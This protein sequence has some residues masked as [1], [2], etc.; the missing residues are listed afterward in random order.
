MLACC[1]ELTVEQLGEMARPTLEPDAV[2]VRDAS[3][4]SGF[5]VGLADG[6]GSLAEGS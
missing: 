5:G 1:G 2:A 3:P 6:G 4:R